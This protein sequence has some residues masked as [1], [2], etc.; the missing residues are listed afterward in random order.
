MNIHDLLTRCLHSEV[1]LSV[2]EGRLRVHYDG[3]LQDAEL[4]TLLR[5]H[6]QQ[7]LQHLSHASGTSVGGIPRL[8]TSDRA[9]TP[10]SLAQRRMWLLDHLEHAGAAYNMV[11]IYRLHGCFDSKAMQASLNEVL[12]RHEALRTILVDR[13]GQL[14]Q[15]I[16]VPNEVPF[17]GVDLSTYSQDRQ[18]EALAD[19]LARE[20][21]WRFDLAASP[22]L[23]ATCIALG[24]DDWTVILNVHH[25]ACDGESIEILER[26]ISSLYTAF[27][28]SEPIP[29]LPSTVQY[30]D[31][32]AW[33]K[34]FADDAGWR[35]H[36]DY[37]VKNLEGMP[38]LHGLPLDKPRPAA[39][40]YRGETLRRTMT[41]VWLRN[42]QTHCQD[43]GA[44]IF[45]FLH[46]ALAALLCV[47]SN[48]SDIA[49][50]FPVAG[51][52]HHD[53]ENTVGLFV[54]TLVLRT[55]LQGN[56]SFTEML[57]ASR[58]A[59]VDALAHQDVPYDALVNALRSGTGHGG[60][61]QIFLVMRNKAGSSLR[62][63]GVEVELGD[64]LQA[65]I[66]FDLQVEAEQSDEGLVID[67]RFNR[68]L[69][70]AASMAHLVDCLTH[71]L[72]AAVDQPGLRLFSL[73]QAAPRSL[74]TTPRISDAP[75]ARIEARFEVHVAG[76]RDCPAV[77]LH[78]KVLTY[79]VL[80]RRADAVAALLRER[81]IQRGMPVGLCTPRSPEAIV[82][83]LGVL[84]AGAAY[85]PLD[86]AYPIARLGM[87]LEDCAATL[88]LTQ[89]ELAADLVALGLPLVVLDEP[90]PSIKEDT[91]KTE[92]AADGSNDPAYVIYTSGTTGSPK[93]V[94]VAHAGV[95]N[96]LDH[97]DALSKP[98]APW[99]G[100]LWS[101]ISF[102]VSVYEIFSV[103]C[104]GGT[105]H[106]VP[107]AVRQDPAPLFR[108]LDESAI[109]ST[110][111][112]A[113]YLEPFAE[114]VANGKSGHHLRRMLVGVEPIASDHLYAI[115]QRLPRLDIINGYGPTETTVCC[116]TYRFDPTRHVA[117]TRV[118]IGLA[119]D[120][121][122]LHVMNA[123]GEPAPLGAVGELYVGGVGVA[124]GYRSNA[125]LTEARFITIEVDGV[126]RRVYRTG[127][128]VRYRADGE[129]EFI[130]R[131]DE[132][133]KIRGFRVEPGEIEVRLCQQRA[134]SDA[135][136]MALGDGVGRRLVAYVVPKGEYLA[137]SLESDSFAAQVKRELRQHLPGYMIP[138]DIVAMAEIP[139]TVNGKVNRA[140]L[141]SLTDTRGSVERL[142]PRNDTERRI[143]D[144]W[145]EVLQLDDV[146][147]RDDF[148]ALG[149]QSLLAMRVI[150]RV[151]QVFQLGD[152]EL[153][154]ATLFENPTVETFAEVMATAA[155]HERIRRQEA[156]LASLQ[157][158]VEEGTL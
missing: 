54:N 142:A 121:M 139:L 13:D 145:K 47:Y 62:L 71:L 144:I 119:V 48:E 77:I 75:F 43:A 113:G 152:A 132:Q 78:D 19:L 69:F 124:L 81:G 73:M 118:P 107:D 98:T 146:G 52:T 24:N 49:V 85:V 117:G 6:K 131:A 153:P 76:Q 56:P 32:I 40:S 1:R 103:L 90:L 154:F 65:P 12:V 151:R 37:W 39:P 68:S 64:N 20:N 141:R 136:V 115:T 44:T 93:G 80:N 66:K 143:A 17:D 58:H 130:G 14:R 18:A 9:D 122:T 158:N 96:L 94:V 55:C 140:T 57:A 89:K 79:E 108:W 147:I 138:D 83:M 105:L 155:K 128:L 133:I 135:V 70:D 21:D 50:G 82:G 127:D 31:Y 120:G 150:G 35:T 42:A 110:F 88:V 27:A 111:M 129:L 16:Q 5:E 4:L 8:R 112:H 26:E 149:G 10:A 38:S 125:M 67:W 91:E 99:S 60:L 3:E 156:Y 92:Q 29:K 34:D 126:A 86:P 114:Y 7:L 123:G 106:I 53:I 59:I 137:K 148:F 36:L 102:D 157:D 41:A 30:A 63:P 61:T 46:A 100:S 45:M 51:R 23:R 22:L 84:K 2:S 25:I 104:N 15:L 95:M 72:E 74:E 97:F 109:V 11:G 33:N 28:A 116:T 101:S 134:I 87:I